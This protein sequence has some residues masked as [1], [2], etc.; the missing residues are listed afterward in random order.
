MFYQY[1]GQ[2]MIKMKIH[3]KAYSKIIKDIWLRSVN[4]FTEDIID[5]EWYSLPKMLSRFL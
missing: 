2:E 3:L 5:D 4:A 1:F